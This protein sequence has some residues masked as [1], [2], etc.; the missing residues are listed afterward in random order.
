[1]FTSILV[2]VDGSGLSEAALTVAV[3]LAR[4][5]NAE[6][7]VVTVQA[8]PPRLSGSGGAPVTDTL[9]DVERRQAAMEY[10][11]QL[12]A[13]ISAEA[14]GVRIHTERLEGRVADALADR[15]TEHPHDLVVMTTHGHRGA[16]RRWLGNVADSLVRMSPAPVL[17]LTDASLGATP[18]GAPPFAN[19]LVPIAPTEESEEILSDAI[20]LAGVA[21]SYLLF[22]VVEPLPF[23]PRSPLDLMSVTDAAGEES[24]APRSEFDVAV[25]HLDELAAAL[26][27]RGLTVHTSVAIHRH[28]AEAILAQAAELSSPLIAM[29]TR[30]HGST[31]RFFL[32]SVTDKVLRGSS[33]PVLLRAP[34]RS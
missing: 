6:L 16:S 28:P 4:Q 25:A 13:R 21:A 7:H 12:G 23:L 2:P 9:F 18:A 19:V 29:F 14:D 11:T 27:R 24:H 8:P 26:R 15:V 17:L 33:V 20:A 22:A 31:R 1:M 10:L 3:P 30:G 5:Y 34:D 32:G